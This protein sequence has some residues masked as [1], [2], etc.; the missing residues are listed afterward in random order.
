MYK[1]DDRGDWGLAC[2]MSIAAIASVGVAVWFIRELF[3]GIAWLFQYL[4]KNC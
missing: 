1:E 3:L 4:L 2:F